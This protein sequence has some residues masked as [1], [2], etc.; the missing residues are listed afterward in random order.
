M[1]LLLYDNKG[2]KYIELYF[3]PNFIADDLIIIF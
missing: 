1:K 3:T 2:R